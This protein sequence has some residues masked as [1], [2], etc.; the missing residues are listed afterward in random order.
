MHIHSGRSLELS[1]V[2]QADKERHDA[3]DAE[4]AIDES[5]IKRDASD[6]SGDERQGQHAG[7][8]D[9]SENDHPFVAYRVD[10][11]TKEGH[12]DG[13]VSEGEP[14]GAVS[15]EGVIAIRV[16][17]SLVHAAQPDVKS[18]FGAGKGGWGYAEDPVQRSGFV[19]QGEGGDATEDEA[20]DED[21]EPDSDCSD[22]PD[23][24]GIGHRIP[25]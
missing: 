1:D 10:E 21:G 9:H 11:R 3:D 18:G 24:F 23:C 22:H 5:P 25:L 8:C 17:D 16:H 6:G 12:G 20:D 4:A 2:A 14:I 19:F 13:E 15:H 7:A